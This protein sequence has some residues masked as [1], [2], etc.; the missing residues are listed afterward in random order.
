MRRDQDPGLGS[1]FSKPVNRLL[2]PNGTY[3]IIRYGGVRGLKDLY[4]YLLEINWV[5]F[6][7]LLFLLYVAINALFASG[8]VLLDDGLAGDLPFFSTFWKSFFFSTQTFTTL[9]YG[10][11]SPNSFSANVLASI[12]SFVGLM[13]FALAT[14]LLYGRFSKPSSKIAFS[15]NVILRTLDGQRTMM[16]KLVNQRDNVLLKTKINVI[17]ILDKKDQNGQYNKEYHPLKLVRNQVLFFPLTWTVVHTIDH[18]SP[19]FNLELKDLQKRN[20]ELVILLET[21]DET[22]GH[23]IVQKHS[24][25][26]NQWIENVKFDLNFKP[27]DSGQVELF[28]NELDNIS[29]LEK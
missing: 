27:N 14:G 13:F 8:F 1:L 26:E 12:E 22:F 29:P 25:A 6:I 5:S 16:F 7:G 17:L 4:K 21:F 15:K 20:A 24:Y 19:L 9:G 3:N 28:V 23:E 18:D 10:V 11:I 2:N